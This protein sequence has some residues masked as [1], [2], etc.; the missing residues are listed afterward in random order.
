MRTTVH[1]DVSDILS[2]VHCAHDY[3]HGNSVFM[4][5]MAGMLG[6]Q[7]ADEEILAYAN[8]YTTPEMVAKGY[9]EEDRDSAI[10]TLREFKVRYIGGECG[11]TTTDEEAQ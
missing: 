10:E 2:L 4:D 9:S 3:G 5:A 1:V 8:D 6:R 11:L 7:L